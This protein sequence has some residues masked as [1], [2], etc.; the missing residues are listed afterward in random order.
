VLLLLVLH[1][2]DRMLTLARLTEELLDLVAIEVGPSGARLAYE[3]E[4]CCCSSC[5][6]CCTGIVH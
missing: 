6:C 2:R 4:A 3:L 1:M 5:T